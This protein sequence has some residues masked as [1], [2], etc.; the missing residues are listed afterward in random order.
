MI[1]H[2]ESKTKV[3]ILT[4]YILLIALLLAGIVGITYQ[5]QKL[6]EMEKNN[7]ESENLITVGYVLATLY[8]AESIGNIVYAPNFT[9]DYTMLGRKDS[10]VAVVKNGIAELKKRADN[11]DLTQKLDTVEILL[12]QKTD[13]ERQIVKL[14]DSI[15]KLPMQ[16]RQIT[17]VLS[18]K[19]LAHLATVIKNRD[20]RLMDSTRVVIREKTFGEKFGDLF[21]S[22]TK[23]SLIVRHSQNA[24]T[25]DELVPVSVTLDTISQYV[26]D[27]LYERSRKSLQMVATL[28]VRQM[29]LQ[30][31][32]ETLFGKINMILRSLEQ[33]EFR[34]KQQL[35]QEQNHALLRSNSIGNIVALAALAIAIL[36]IITTIRLLNKQRDYRQQLEKQNAQ[37]ENLLKL[38]EWMILSISHDIKAPTSSILSYANLLSKND[39]PQN[40]QNYIA[41]MKN[42]SLQVLEL[43]NNLLNFHKLE[44]RELVAKISDFMPYEHANEVFF[45]FKSVAQSKNLEYG[46][47]NSLPENLQCKSDILFINQ[48]VNNLISNALKYTEKGKIELETRFE[49]TEGKNELIFSVTDTGIGISANDLSQLFDKFERTQASEIQRIEGFG[50]GLAISQKLAE[51]LN[52]QISVQSEKGKGSTFT[53][54]VPANDVQ[55]LENV[56]QNAEQKQIVKKKLL[57]IDDDLLMLKVC[58]EM[59]KEAGCEPY[60]TDKV[61][62]VVN[63]LNNNKIDIVFCD[64]K[65]PEMSG[66]ALAENIRKNV[67]NPPPLV[68]L[69]AIAT[70]TDDEL[71]KKGFADFLQKP[72]SINELNAVINKL[73]NADTPTKTATP[74]NFT[75][76]LNYALGDRKASKMILRTF[77]DENV[78]IVQKIE[79]AIANRDNAQI[80]DLAHKLLPRMQMINNQE[81]IKILCALELGKTTTFAKQNLMQ[82]IEK[83]NQEALEFIENGLRKEE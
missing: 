59:T 66:F 75:S 16:Q 83:V 3:I 44:Q 69:S 61:N 4:G 34:T 26:T 25:E 6:S 50:L 23:D 45:R 48:I 46:I 64:I 42:S 5:M 14:L 8:K 82:L 36:F 28:S 13:N 32:N 55:I 56:P 22:K 43:V 38:R 57:F 33:R 71:Y 73:A 78:N 60:A 21:R 10:L 1:K 47:K 15:M 7:S 2:S 27:F 54:R 29:E 40:R 12:A 76:L 20:T 74:A 39:L 19:E 30:S 79:T 41:N 80:K 9:I 65:M 77:I 24:E 68:A 18:Q 67:K 51:L 58:E 35:A 17:T 62:N 70:R 53:L 81:I 72:F 11:G 31:T 49:Q 63:I 52:G 37:I